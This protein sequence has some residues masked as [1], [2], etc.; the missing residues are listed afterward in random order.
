MGTPWIPAGSTSEIEFRH[1]LLYFNKVC[2]VMVTPFVDP[3][4]IHH[5]SMV[6]PPS[7]LGT[8]M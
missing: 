8:Y 2:S 4:W 1:F 5:G 3:K 7:D 6:N